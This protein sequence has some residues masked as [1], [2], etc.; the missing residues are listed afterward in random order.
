MLP[1]GPTGLGAWRFKSHAACEQYFGAG[2]QAFRMEVM[3]IQPGTH[4]GEMT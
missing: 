1:Q 3:A 2:H 4:K